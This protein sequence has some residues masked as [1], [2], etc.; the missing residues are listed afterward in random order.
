MESFKAAIQI[1]QPMTDYAWEVLQPRL[2]AQLPAAEQA[3]AEHV[4]RVT[5]LQSRAAERRQQ[6]VSLKE[7]KEVLDREWE[8][9]MKPIRD[10]L[11]AIADEFINRDWNHGKAVTYE[12][13][14]KFAVDLL[15][16]VR[17]EFYAAKFGDVS[18]AEGQ[19]KVESTSESKLVLDNMKW[20]YDNKVKPL[21]EQFRKELFLCN[22]GGSCE[23]NTRFYGFEGVIQHYGAKH[24]NAFSV[25]NVVVAWREAEWPEEPPFHP[26]PIAAKHL[27][28]S[29]TG[30]GHSAY[31]PYHVGYSSRADTVTPFVQA[32]IAHASPGPYHPQ[33]GNHYNGPYAPPP[34]QVPAYDYPHSYGGPPLDT[35]ASYTSPSYG[36][37]P[38]HSGYMTSPA[39][40]HSA[41]P[42]GQPSGQAYGRPGDRFPQAVPRP[43]AEDVKYRTNLFENQVSS[44]IRMAQEI[45][46]Q[47]SGVKD[48]PSSVRIYVLMQRI[49]SKFQLEFNHEPTLDHL[50]DAFSNHQIPKGLKNA[51][52]LFC[53]ACQ[54]EFL[55]HVAVPYQS[56]AE[57][58][59]TYT[60]LNLF[61]HF[62][63]QHFAHGPLTPGALYGN[64]ATLDWKEDM[65]ELPSDRVISGLIHAPGMTDEKL[66]MIATVFPSLFPTPLP[67]IASGVSHDAGSPDRPL[68]KDPKETSA[69]IGAIGLQAERSGPSSVASGPPHSPIHPKP[70]DEEY[71]PLRPALSTQSNQ[72]AR[73]SNRRVPYQAPPPS[74]RRQYSGESRYFVGDAISLESR[75]FE[76]NSPVPQLPRDSSVSEYPRPHSREYLDIGPNSKM[77]R[78]ADS[79]EQFQERNPLYR[80]REEFFQPGPDGVLYTRHP[81]GGYQPDE[82][83]PFL[84]EFRRRDN[85]PRRSSGYHVVREAD[86]HESLPSTLKT[87]AEQF[88]D[89]F[90]PMDHS[91]RKGMDEPGIIGEAK[92]ASNEAEFDDGSRYTPPPANAPVPPT[93]VSGPQ[94]APAAPVPALPSS[95]ASGPRFEEYRSDGRQIPTPDSGGAPRKSGSLRRRDRPH[96]YVPSRYYRYMTVARDEQPYPRSVSRTQSRRY[97]RYEEQKRRL[98]QADTPQANPDADYDRGYSRDHSLDR[99]AEPAYHNIR[100]GSREYIPIE[101]PA[102]SYPPVHYRVAPGP[103]HGAPPSYVDQYGQPVELVRVHR[104]PRPYVGHPPTTRYVPEPN[105]DHHIQYVPLSYDRGHPP[106]A[107][108]AGDPRYEEHRPY[109]YYEERGRPSATRFHTLEIADGD[110]GESTTRGTSMVPPVPGG[111]ETG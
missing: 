84:Q 90:D 110:P 37:P 66:H 94:R 59:R 25:G 79:Y 48:L 82:Y 35:Y 72:A 40:G 2:L 44:V 85:E 21:T 42:R 95:Q 67:R 3:E 63:S 81:H 106:H 11:N 55:H 31:N 17:R 14:P 12:N 89:D 88:L 69:I 47:T 96:D 74:S 46:K 70:S 9:A 77:I 34:S 27:L 33:Y 45:W 97:S 107:P 71:D 64:P 56:R 83:R 23:G 103:P 4:S 62:K 53:K 75:N 73:S 54:E 18:P 111:P 58:R 29:S 49:I 60:V 52:G 65:L 10:K 13:S 43:E 68:P 102:G 38:G 50:I 76:A 98:D 24:T 108:R 1:S 100:H 16:Y 30:Q 99:Q 109:V 93:D 41:L 92:P 61:S 91:N 15:L 32:R 39:M 7:V 105:S 80:D 6:D 57:D 22:G 101:D 26:D 36:P 51:S 86:P 78:D 19:V 20:V 28:H 5:S 87:E 8:E 104:D